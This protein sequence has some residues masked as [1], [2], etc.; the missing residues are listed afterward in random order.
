MPEIFHTIVTAH[1]GCWY[2]HRI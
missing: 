2:E 1:R